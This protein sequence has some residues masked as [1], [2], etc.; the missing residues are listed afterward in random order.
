VVA[1]TMSGLGTDKAPAAELL[2][3]AE[4]ELDALL[5]EDSP[6]WVVGDG[7]S[8]EPPPHA[9]KMAKAARSDE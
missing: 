3:D 8:V 2:E 9:L 6:C 5:L 1:E 7:L 4:L